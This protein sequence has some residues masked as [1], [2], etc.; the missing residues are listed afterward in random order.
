MYK[1]FTIF[2]AILTIILSIGLAACYWN[3]GWLS[4]Q[5]AAYLASIFQAMS[6]VLSLSFI[7]AQ[8]RQQTI[9]VRQQA[10]LARAAN[11]QSFVGASSSFVLTVGGNAD[12]MDLYKSGGE[13]FE[14]LRDEKQAQYRYLVGWWL[15]F[16]ENVLY[17]HD[18]GLLD[19][20]V[21]RAWM[22]DMEGFIVRRSVEKVWDSLKDN[23]SD[24]FVNHFQPRIDKR[25]QSLVS[26]SPVPPKKNINPRD[27]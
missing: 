25:R 10:E 1:L 26:H 24:A 21:Y 5:S 22:K 19:E 4:I 13:R 17:Q 9:S 11:S 3:R 6:V 20:S 23:Y 18:C 15:T 16:Y 8:L 12:L 7:A 2:L 27:V 14:T